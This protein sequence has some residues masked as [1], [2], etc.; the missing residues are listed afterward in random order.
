MVRIVLGFAGFAAEI[1]LIARDQWLAAGLTGAGVLLVIALIP[2]F[3]QAVG[4]LRGIWAETAARMRRVTEPEL[5]P[6]PFASVSAPAGE[7]YLCSRC[8]G[9]GETSWDDATA[10]AARHAGVC[11]ECFGN[12]LDVLQEQRVSDEDETTWM[13]AHD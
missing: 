7:D 4:E 3:A 11:A 6:P 12:L 8:G 10:R 9:P 5:P 2:P 13:A 1:A